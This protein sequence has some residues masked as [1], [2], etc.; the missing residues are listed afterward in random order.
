MFCVQYSSVGTEKQCNDNGV[1]H[2]TTFISIRNVN[3]HG[4]ELQLT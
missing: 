2:K 1:T 3:R 4:G